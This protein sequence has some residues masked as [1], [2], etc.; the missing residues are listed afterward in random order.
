[1]LTDKQ[2]TSIK[3]MERSRQQ[4]LKQ[5]QTLVKVQRD[6]QL[7]KEGG[8]GEAS[9]T[10]LGLHQLSAKVMSSRLG[11]AVGLESE[12]DRNA[13][14][15]KQL[16][17]LNVEERSL[18]A[19]IT[20]ALASEKTY[21]DSLRD[22]MH[23]SLAAVQEMMVQEVT[24]LR[25]VLMTLV[26]W[27][28][29]AM[30][31]FESALTDIKANLVE[32]DLEKDLNYFAENIKRVAFSDQQNDQLISLT[33]LVFEP[34]N[35]ALIEEAIK[36][37]DIVVDSSIAILSDGED[38]D[39]D[40]GKSS[41]DTPVGEGV[42]R[43][44]ITK[45]R[46]VSPSPH[47][48]AS[49]LRSPETRR[50][51][52]EMLEQPRLVVPSESQYEASYE[53]FV[54][55]LNPMDKVLETFNCA[56][57]PS[58]SGLMSQGR[59]F[60]T[61]HY[62]AFAGFGGMGA[63]DGVRILLAL[64]DIVKIEKAFTM[65]IFPTALLITDS[66]DDDYFFGSFLDRDSCFSMLSNMSQAEKQLA[67]MDG[68]AV[69]KRNLVL[70]YQTERPDRTN[71]KQSLLQQVKETVR[72]AEKGTRQ[73]QSTE[74]VSIEPIPLPAPLD[75]SLT[76][77]TDEDNKTDVLDIPAFFKQHGI[78][79]LLDETIPHDIQSVYHS[80]WLPA[81]G[82]GD[83]L[84]GEGDVGLNYDEWVAGDV[85]PPEDST[86][87]TYSYTRNFAFEHP[88]TTMLFIGP[89]NAPAKQVQYLYCGGRNVDLNSWRPKQII[90]TMVSKFQG[91]PFADTFK[92]VMYWCVS[93][94]GNDQTKI[95]LGV[96]LYWITQ[97]IFRSQII[98]GTES[99][100]SKTAK[101]YISYC[102]EKLGHRSTTLRLAPLDESLQGP[103]AAIPSSDSISRR[104]QESVSNDA[105]V[106][107]SLVFICIC[108]ALLLYNQ[109]RVNN[110]IYSQINDLHSKLD[111]I[112]GQFHAQ[113]T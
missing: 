6:I 60:I 82:Y 56:L 74:V 110:R 94:I 111:R 31:P 86:G 67:K 108:L 52:R 93:D 95:Y 20:A 57:Y 58:S 66:S 70:G 22:D 48:R 53:L 26:D 72:T 40:I 92:V 80:C 99:E 15:T 23:M 79:L 49:D 45:P 98:A 55:G 109:S 21:K 47:E 62:M 43:T 36:K 51:S 71:S 11:V 97:T 2:G 65:G 63:W 18:S 13:R 3:T 39:E 103:G 83:F 19:A 34:L 100:L 28:S 89:K 85:N 1:M 46:S 90:N 25:S 32:V 44:E 37:G 50:G 9:R 76:G 78:R 105:I 88:R 54:F 8:D 73:N 77:I 30:E 41:G 68:A 4:L 38:E 102:I 7:L 16:D 113:G 64:K 5:N 14:I 104:H 61:Q 29:S 69:D 33:T 91:F 112:L 35:S 84:V 12:S 27:N 81:K 75:E 87:L 17:G 10:T 106:K 107:Y 59:M 96:K 42:R 24:Y 101:R